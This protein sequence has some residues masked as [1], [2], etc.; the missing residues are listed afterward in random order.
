[1]IMMI[2]LKRLYNT[3]KNV[4]QNEIINETNFVEEHEAELAR[5]FLK[6]KQE[7]RPQWQ[8]TKRLELVFMATNT[9]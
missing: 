7:M 6:F 2:Y 9:N 8:I 1:M 5:I 3:K 4:L